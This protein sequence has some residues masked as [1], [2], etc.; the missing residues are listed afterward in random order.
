MIPGDADTC[1]DLFGALF[2]GDSRSNGGRD[3]SGSTGGTAQVSE[4]AC[5][6]S[7]TSGPLGTVFGGGAEAQVRRVDAAGFVAAVAEAR[8]VGFG[9]SKARDHSVYKLIGEEMGRHS[10]AA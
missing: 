1:F 2:G 8:V 6:V 5:G 3:G 4:W 9:P 10:T 7:A